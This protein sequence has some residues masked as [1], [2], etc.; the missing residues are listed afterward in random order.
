MRI[1]VV[2]PHPDDESLGAGGSL[3]KYKS[4][5]HNI[6]WLNITDMKKEYGYHQEQIEKRNSE[7]ETVQQEYKFDGFYNLKL[8]PT[9]LDEYKLGELI[10]L[11]KAV[12]DEV[13]PDRLIL[14]YGHD[15]HSDHRIIFDAAYAC[16]KSFRAPYLKELYCME[17]I[18]ETDQA[19]E[20][21]TFHPNVYVNITEYIEKKIE[22]LKNYK[23]EIKQ[24][25]YPRNEDAIKGLAAL[26]G[27]TAGYPYCEAFRLLKY[28][29]E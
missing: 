2:S 6:F 10:V 11:I 15:V 5:G 27:A 24:S 12:L 29:V 13:Q 16:T 28:Y 9:G 25:P 3:L 8:K 19:E 17:I 7:I 14:P 20:A 26:R 18:S 22:I 23:S 1:M 21:Y 4:E